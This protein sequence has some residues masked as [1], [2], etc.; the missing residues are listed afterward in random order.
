ML[1]RVAL[2]VVLCLGL[3]GFGTVI[4]IETRPVVE[5]KAESGPSPVAATTSV[6]VAARGIRAG[7]SDA[8]L[9]RAIPC[10]TAPWCARAT[11]GSCQRYSTPACGP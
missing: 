7:S 9:P 8:P 2:F 1:M 5:A 6:Q 3:A 4:W 10:P 11:T